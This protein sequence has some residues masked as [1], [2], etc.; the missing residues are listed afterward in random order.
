MTRP[1]AGERPGTLRAAVERLVL[2]PSAGET[3]DSGRVRSMRAPCGGLCHLS[4]LPLVS[5]PSV[6]RRFRGRRQRGVLPRR[7]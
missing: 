7:S 1:S 2:R 3:S 5:L 4:D 6:G